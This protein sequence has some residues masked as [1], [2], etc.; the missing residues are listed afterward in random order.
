SRCAGRRRAGR[1]S[2]WRR[3]GPTMTAEP[4]RTAERGRVVGSTQRSASSGAE[5]GIEMEADTDRGTPEAPETRVPERVEMEADTD[6]GTPE[7]AETPLSE[8][9]EAILLIIDEP[10]SLVAL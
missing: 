4:V 3:W 9:V 6:R 10:I 5:E 8:R 7:V 2:S 1:T